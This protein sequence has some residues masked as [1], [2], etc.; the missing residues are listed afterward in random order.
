MAFYLLPWSREKSRMDLMKR[1]L[2]EV[3]KDK[4]LNRFPELNPLREALIRSFGVEISPLAPAYRRYKNKFW[5][6][7]SFWA[8]PL[9]VQEDI[10]EK[11]LVFSP[12][13]GV[14]GAGDPIPF[15]ELSWKDAYEGKELKDF[16]REHLSQLL[17]KLFEGETVYDF[18]STEERGAV[19]FPEGTRRVLFEY[20][21]G[22]KRVINTLPHR[23]YTL[24]YIVEKDVT[25][26]TLHKINFLDY[27]VK[28]VREEE[29]YVKVILQSEGKYI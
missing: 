27:K 19:S 21:R 23:A 9:K 8:L 12:L 13:F 5:E 25:L 4:E 10:K 6:E 2:F 26:E 14:I 24:R 3:W 18:T 1:D 7:L 20:Y 17:G 29:S 11:G 28:D 22:D 16:W 15:Y